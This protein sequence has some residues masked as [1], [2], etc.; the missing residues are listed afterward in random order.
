MKHTV[1]LCFCLLGLLVFAN[2]QSVISAENPVAYNYMLKHYGL[3]G[4]VKKVTTYGLNNQ[5]MTDEIFDTEGRLTTYTSFSGSTSK[6]F[7]TYD[8]K[9]KLIEVSM[10]TGNLPAIK[11][12]YQYNS[13]QEVEYSLYKVGDP[14]RKYDYRGTQLIKDS[15]ANKYS[16]QKVYYS[17]YEYNNKGQLTKLTAYNGGDKLSREEM[18][19]Y[20]TNIVTIKGKGY[21]S[22]GK[23]DEYERK[24]YYDGKGSLIKSTYTQNG[25]TETTEYKLDANG[26]WIWKTGGMTR[27]ITYYDEAGKQTNGSAP[28][29]SAQVLA[30]NVTSNKEQTVKIIPFEPYE[31]NYQTAISNATNTTEPKK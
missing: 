30:G 29:K 14:L 20:E 9:N 13:N 21:W 28:S 17:Y 4:K 2:G 5:L 25:K 19:S 26:N 23:V 3:K 22:I 24:K 10:Q 31:T 11:Y 12:L 7:Y 18:Y 6:S 27:Q 15:G 16:T 1:S 8:T